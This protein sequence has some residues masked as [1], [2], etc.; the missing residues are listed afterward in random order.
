MP[1]DLLAVAINI[2]VS[3]SRI[4]KIKDTYLLFVN[5]VQLPKLN[6]TLTH[7]VSLLN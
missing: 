2:L 3:I 1:N 4:D 7:Y 5:S 6:P